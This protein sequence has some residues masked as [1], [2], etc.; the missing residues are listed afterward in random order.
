MVTFY[1]ATAHHRDRDNLLAG[2]KSAFD[3]FEGI[4]IEN[5]RNLTYGPVVIAVDKDDPRVEIVVMG[6]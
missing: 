6:L 3:G 1:F 4:L 2:L 5:D